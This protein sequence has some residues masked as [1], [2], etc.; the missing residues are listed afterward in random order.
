MQGESQEQWPGNKWKPLV[1]IVLAAHPQAGTAGAA[2]RGGGV[3]PL[4]TSPF[5]GKEK[6]GAVLE[7]A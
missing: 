2:G 5:K 3:I 6:E 4:T 1:C 7:V